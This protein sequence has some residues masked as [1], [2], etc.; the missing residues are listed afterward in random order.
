MRV[1]SG[2]DWGLPLMQLFRDGAARDSVTGSASGVRL[3]VVGLGVDDQGGTATG[4][5]GV[6]AIAHVH[7]RIGDGRLR[8]ALRIDFEVRHVAS[9]WPVGIIEAVMLLVGIEMR[10]SAG[11]RR[12]ALG[13]LMDVQGVFARGQVHQI[14]L[15]ADAGAALDLGDDGGADGLSCRVAQL[16]GDG[17]G[18]SEG[19]RGEEN[20]GAE[21]TKR[22]GRHGNSL[23]EASSR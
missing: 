9:V 3:H 19:R 14:Q 23:Q 1:Y 6:I 22:E 16:D 12:F 4:E 13:V 11:E 17:F 18:G 10:A 5:D 8:L 20:S 7:T 15:D 21:G 2:Q